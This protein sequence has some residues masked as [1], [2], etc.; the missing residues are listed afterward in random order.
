MW[1]LFLLIVSGILIADALADGEVLGTFW[2]LLGKHRYYR[3]RSEDP[4]GV[5]METLDYCN[6]C[7]ASKPKK[8]KR[9]KISKAKTGTVLNKRKHL[10]L[11]EGGKR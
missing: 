2:C 3:T 4:M 6:F 8:K 1:W 7:F 10:T 11:I 9:K 5:S